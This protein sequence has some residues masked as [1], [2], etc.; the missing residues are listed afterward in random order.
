MDSSIYLIKGQGIYP[1]LYALYRLIL[2]A[3]LNT[4]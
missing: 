2:G 3:I 1:G 4:S